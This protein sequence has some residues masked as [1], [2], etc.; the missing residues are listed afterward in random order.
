MSSPIAIWRA[1]G[2][3]DVLSKGRFCGGEG[4]INKFHRQRRKKKGRMHGALARKRKKKK[5]GQE[6]GERIWGT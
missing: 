1:E 6:G 2:K 5:K 4:T 3:I